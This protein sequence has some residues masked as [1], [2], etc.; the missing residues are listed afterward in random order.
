MYD[1]KTDTYTE[2][3]LV[4]INPIWVEINDIPGITSQKIDGNISVHWI[5]LTDNN[6][7]YTVSDPFNP[8]HKVYVDNAIDNLRDEL[9]P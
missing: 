1:V 9:S 4:D 6:V 2:D 3:F 7:P 8:A 5:L